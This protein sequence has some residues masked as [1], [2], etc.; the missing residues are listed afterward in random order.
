MHLNKTLVSKSLRHNMIF[1]SLKII[2]VSQINCQLKNQLIY[3]I[4]SLEKAIKIF[5]FQTF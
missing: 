5:Q 4:I 2:T 3:P 1:L